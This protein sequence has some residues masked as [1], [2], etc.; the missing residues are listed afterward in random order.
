[1]VRGILNIPDNAWVRRVTM[2]RQVKDILFIG[3][4][5]VMASI[6]LKG[7][8]L[9]NGFF[10]GGAM[11]VSLL[12]EILTPLDLSVLIVLVNLPFIY[13]GYKQLNLRFAIKSTFAIFA[14]ALLVHY[15]ELPT[16]TADKLLIAVFGGFF[17]G[18][19]YWFFD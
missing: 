18:K 8:L 13:L 4:G 15:I 16:I 5:V 12:L 11:G 17:F 1:M 10:D 2:W 7:F 6:G 9:P 14:L 3:I 19:R